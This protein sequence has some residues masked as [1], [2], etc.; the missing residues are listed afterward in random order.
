MDTNLPLLPKLDPAD[1]W[2]PW[3]PDSQ[4]PWNL[5]WAAHLFRRAAFG[6]P[7][8][9]EGVSAWDAHQR[10]VQ[11][12]LDAALEQVFEGLPGQPEFEGMLDS[13]G[14]KI[15]KSPRFEFQP[16]TGLGEIQSWWIYR[17]VFSPHP[18]L[19]KM[20]LF[21]H[22]HFATSV[23]KVKKSTLML[24]QNQLIRKHALGKFQP[25]LLEMS[26][27]PAMLIWL[28]G[29]AN[30]KSHPNENYAR[31]L[32]ELF[33]LGVGNYTEKDIREAARAFTG[34]HMAGTEFLYNPVQH[35][36]GEKT[37]LGQTGRWD[38]GDVIRIALEQP[39]AARFLVRKLYRYLI[40]ENEPPP[41]ALL[42]PLAEQLRKTE[43]DIGQLVRTMLC[44]RLFF[45]QHAYR[46]RIKSPAEYVVGLVRTLDIRG[47]PD[48]LARSMIDLGQ[49]LFAP[50]NVK[51]WDGGKA[52]LNSGTVLARHNLAWELLND[53]SSMA[54][55]YVPRF[56]GDFALRESGAGK[57]SA[58]PMQLE[59]KPAAEQV[60]ALLDLALQGDVPDPTRQKLIAFLGDAS[61]SNERDKEPKKEG[62]SPS[63]PIDQDQRLRETLHTILLL[64]EY[65][66][67]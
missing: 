43:Y 28:D 23:A 4:N 53:A 56:P 33:S 41:E 30:V 57:L 27:D 63:P 64:P 18:L 55:A 32:L 25:L 22:N 19:E 65:Q 1:A 44:S 34:W 48:S 11:Q 37:I 13:L 6:V 46:Q 45:S 24:R 67:A 51:G 9:Q 54:R 60:V 66:L 8:Y 62:G 20:S 16:D 17:M 61:A 35:D 50:P 21:W 38:G 5:K 40:S 14:P 2:R 58:L 39:A 31:E 7:A 52:W 42:E 3:Q 49:K 10:A 36:D 59:G 47:R 29:N 26:K 12:G 15:G